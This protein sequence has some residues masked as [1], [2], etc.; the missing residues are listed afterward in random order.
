MNLYNLIL[1][2]FI[3]SFAGWIIEII[4]VF[5]VTKKFTINRGFFLGPYLPIYGTGAILS[6]LLWGN[7]DL[8]LLSL[9]LKASLCC[10]VLEYFTSYIMEKMFDVRWWDYSDR[11]FNINGRICLINIILF[12]IGCLIVLKLANPLLFKYINS[13]PNGVLKIID[14]ILISIFLTDNIITLIMLFK[15]KHKIKSSLREDSSEEVSELIRKQLLKETSLI[16]RIILSHPR[17]KFIIRQIKQI[18]NKV[19]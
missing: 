10:G 7:S 11:R 19:S 6:T 14:Y 1:L 4:D 5:I 9:F 12:G 3:Y 2:F 16:K 13:I 18:K 17:V 8:D 15:I